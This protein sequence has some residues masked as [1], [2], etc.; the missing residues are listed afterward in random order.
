[1]RHL[2][3][4][5]FGFIIFVIIINCQSRN[6]VNTCS[7]LGYAEPNNPDDC[8]EDGEICCYV[9][10]TDDQSQ[11]L[12]F[13]VSSPSDIEMDDVKDEIKEY[14]GFTLQNLKCNKSQFIIYNSLKILALLAFMLF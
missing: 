7:G 12:R 1:M 14:T 13:C 3:V 6:V 2:N 4:L 10:I 11:S 9:E 8:K 5:I